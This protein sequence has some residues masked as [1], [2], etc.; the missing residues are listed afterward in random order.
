MGGMDD[1]DRKRKARGLAKGDK[2]GKG[3]RPEWTADKI[4]GVCGPDG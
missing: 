3:N 2:K 1:A 4:E